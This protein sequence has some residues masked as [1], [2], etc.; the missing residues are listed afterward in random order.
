LAL[1]AAPWAAPALAKEATLNK[2]VNTFKKMLRSKD[3]KARTRA[4]DTLR[5]SRD[6]EVIEAVIWGVKEL[7]K[8]GQETVEEQ[9][10][11]EADYEEAINELHEAQRDFETSNRTSR[12]LDRY[13]RRELKIRKARDGA[14]KRLKNLENDHTR[15][16]SVMQ[17]AV[18]VA[19][20]ILSHLDEADLAT[21]LELLD[22]A[23]LRSK[24]ADD[25]MRWVYAV[26]EIRQPLVIRH[27]NAVVDDEE[28]PLA[29]RVASVMALAEMDD[30]GIAEKAIKMLA[31]PPENASMIRAGI[32]ALRAIHDRRVILPL[33][34][35]LE[36]TD[37]KAEREVAHKALV[38]LTGEA[39]GP[40]AQE[41]LK[42]WDDHGQSFEMPKEPKP[43]GLVKQPDKGG[44]F[45]GIHTFSDRILYIVDM[46]GSMDRIQKGKGGGKSKWDIC[47]QEL[48]GAVSSLDNGYAF[49]VIFFN[50]EVLPW[51]N[52]K[53]VASEKT[54][55]MLEKWVEGQQPLGGTNIF[56]ALERGFTVAAFGVTGKEPPPID[57]IFFLADGKPTAG[58]IQDP[59][60]ILEIIREW[61]KTAQ[62]TI[63]A[64]GI[65]ADH[66]VE[67]MKELA[68]IGD[69]RYVAH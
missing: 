65:G 5:D 28:R 25:Q 36:R 38:S 6:P 62:L 17:Q 42:W 43:T 48:V 29:V 22:E 31:L 40:Y 4:F 60:K 39:H 26:G 58:R 9:K 13:N 27:L 53:V 51:Q 16:R 44:T 33:I 1:T 57:T 41:W 2:R 56:D 52:Q 32:L 59:Q 20:E 10:K 21:A 67:F 11:T 49:N 68:R 8:L 19:E 61:N 30:G 23:W 14:I 45:Y 66:D 15:N 63:H 35:F 54:K 18:L 46:S 50:H 64:I 47:V 7:R 24:F 55:K 12:D 69:G 34:R 3:P 37:I